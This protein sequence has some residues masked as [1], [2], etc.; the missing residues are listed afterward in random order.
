MPVY[1]ELVASNIQYF[2]DAEG[3]IQSDP[4]DIDEIRF[5]DLSITYRLNTLPIK[6]VDIHIRVYSRT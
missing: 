6:L 5:H 3:A 2:C 4:N 1:C